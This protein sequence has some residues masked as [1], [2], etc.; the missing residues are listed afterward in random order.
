MAFSLHPPISRNR[1]ANGVMCC[2]WADRVGL[3]VLATLL[4]SLI[5]PYLILPYLSLPYVVIPRFLVPSVRRLWVGHGNGYARRK[6]RS[7]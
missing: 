3:A 1:K 6:S 2:A 7:G 5:L 4:I